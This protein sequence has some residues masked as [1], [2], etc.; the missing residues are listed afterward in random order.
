[1]IRYGYVSVYLK[2]EVIIPV[3]KDI[4]IVIIIMT[5]YHNI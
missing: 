4:G 1:M 3:I 2:I 5:F